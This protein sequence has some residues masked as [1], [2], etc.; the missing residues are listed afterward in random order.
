MKAITVEGGNPTVYS[1][2]YNK[3][4]GVDFSADSMLV[5]KS[6]SPYAVNLISDSAGMPEK[7]P[8]WEKWCY[9][10]YEEPVNGLWCCHI[11]GK[12]HFIA[13]IGTDLFEFDERRSLDR[14][15]SGL[16]N[17][18][19]AAF[20]MNGA[21]YIFAG[22]MYIVY[23]ATPGEP[24]RVVN[25]YVPT[26][27]VNKKPNGE[28]GDF[29]QGYNLIGR[30]WTEEFIGDGVSREFVLNQKNL[31]K[32][33][34]EFTYFENGQ[35]S[36]LLDGADFDVDYEAGKVILREETAP[37][38]ESNTSNVR[39]TVAKEP[40][41]EKRAKIWNAK[42]AT[43]YNDSYVFVCGAERGVDYRSG[44]ND[45]TYF[46]DDGYDNVGTNNTDIMGYC[47]VGEYL[48][49]IKEPSNEEPTIYLRWGEQITD[50]NGNPQTVFYKKQGIAGVGAV[51]K[52]AIGMLGDEP[53]FLSDRG[54]FA[55][56]SNAVTYDRSVQ[57]RS[58]FVNYK[59]TREPNLENAVCCEWNGYFIVGVNG[60]C[61]LL[62][63]RQRTGKSRTN[64]DFVYE[65]YYWENVPATCFLSVGGEL[66]FGTSDGRICKFK[67]DVLDLSRYSDDGQ[68]IVAIWSTCA[69][70]DGHP[71]RMKTMVKKG[72][73][74]TVKPYARSS[75]KIYVRTEKD[76][77]E[78]KAMDKEVRS[79]T[80]DIFDWNN[81]DFDRFTF[82]SNDAPQDIMIKKKI[83][84][85]KRL[86]FI[87]QNDAVDEG[88]GI[89]QIS[90]SYIVLGL[91]KR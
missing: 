88:F 83:K 45:P 28:G 80:A 13:H 64:S 4:K 55:I 43:V 5:D 89:F 22:N 59:L 6:R 67:T 60:N 51:S 18:K 10:G 32:D 41:P 38:A 66:Y 39:I 50:A 37:P 3:F 63:S 1:T 72:C 74:V 73:A 29:L 78:R 8:G 35:W 81:I 27:V 70:D 40:D 71:Q 19:S 84:K 76:A 79:G 26:V 12:T 16:A 17:Q 20:F 15:G 54:V 58:E 14:L 56:T 48:G 57:S 82:N 47:R 91:A 31:A 24:A 7:R 52:N 49:I 85:Y 2:T 23:D 61:Y 53:L 62:D 77:I 87:I 25:G 34:V 9:Y 33:T 86:Q 68:P 30:K 75:A 65:C 44:Y 21:L 36:S 46:P 42:N 11:K 90:K 69:D